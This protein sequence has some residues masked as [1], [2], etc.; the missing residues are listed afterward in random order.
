VSDQLQDGYDYDL[1][2]E[3]VVISGCRGHIGL[4]EEPRQEERAL[5]RIW[6]AR[7]GLDRIAVA[8]FFSLSSGAMRRVLLAR[9]LASRPQL[10]LLDEPCSGLDASSRTLF[11]RSLEEPAM[12]GLTLIYISHHEQDLGPLFTHELRL[13]AGRVLFSGPRP[14]SGSNVSGLSLCNASR[15][16]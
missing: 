2:A 8:P 3:E 14:V 15:A 6:L 12:S 7:L 13:E 9:A 5:A 10:L 4:Y 16:G 11:L 1:N